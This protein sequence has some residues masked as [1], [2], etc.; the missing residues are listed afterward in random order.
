MKIVS[1]LSILTPLAAVALTGCGGGSNGGS[2]ILGDVPAL[3]Q[4][5]NNTFHREILGSYTGTVIYP[6]MNPDDIASIGSCRWDVEMTI[7]IRTSELGCFLDANMT[8]PVT[9]DIVLASSDPL[10]YQCFED[11][12]IRDVLHGARESLSQAQLDAIPFPHPVELLPQPG[13]PNRGPYFGDVTVTAAHI[14]LIDANEQPLRTML[15]NGDGTVVVK[16]LE[17]TTGLLTKEIVP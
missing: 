1:A 7:S 15:F 4:A 9:Q 3:G 12:S 16:S 5:C 2:E 6:S 11:N 17:T 13:V 10:V 14:H 8:A